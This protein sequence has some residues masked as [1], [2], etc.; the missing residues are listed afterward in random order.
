MRTELVEKKRWISG[1]R[2][3]HALN[4]CMLLPGPEAQPCVLNRKMPASPPLRHSRSEA[5]AAQPIRER[6]DGL[7]VVLNGQ[8]LHAVC[9]VTACRVSAKASLPQPSETG[10]QT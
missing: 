10:R 2:F 4:C 6:A 7:C 3:L 5:R 1:A 8:A 9:G